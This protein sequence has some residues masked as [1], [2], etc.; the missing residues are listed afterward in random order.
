ME[1]AP[2]RIE[3]CKTCKY[4]YRD[5]SQEPCAHCTKNAVDNYEPMT[6][7]DYIRSLGD[8]DL[9]LPQIG[10]RYDEKKDIV[11]DNLAEGFVQMEKLI[12]EQPTAYDVDKVVEK[13]KSEKR[14]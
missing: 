12:K 7:G 14:L 1:I 9:L 11:P 3:N 8:A 13:L 10:N 4:K 2:E 5:E 6:N